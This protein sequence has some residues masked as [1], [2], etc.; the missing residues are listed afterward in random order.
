MTANTIINWFGTPEA[1]FVG[2]PIITLVVSISLKLCSKPK[3]GWSDRNLFY[4]GNNISTSAILL[5]FIEFC[6]VARERYIDKIITIFL[7]FV[8]VIII[9]FAMTQFIRS[10][11]WENSLTN[12]I[13]LKIVRGIIIPDLVG[14]LLLLTCL[15]ILY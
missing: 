7:T 6:N 3:I 13:Q 9:A 14:F 8:I 12:R 10:N 5:L 2:I 4:L 11:G 15:I 1:K